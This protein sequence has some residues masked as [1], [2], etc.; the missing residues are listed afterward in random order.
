MNHRSSSWYSDALRFSNI[1]FPFLLKLRL[2]FILLIDG[3]YSQLNFVNFPSILNL[4]CVLELPFEVVFEPC[5]TQNRPS[6]YP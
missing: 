4:I 6:L 3:F 1:A 2:T 5:Q